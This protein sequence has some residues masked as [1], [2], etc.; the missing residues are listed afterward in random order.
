MAANG[1]EIIQRYNRLKQNRANFDARW[2]EM[3]PYIAP[4]RVG[5]TS[6]PSPGEK[7]TR[8]VYDSSTMMAAEMMAMFIAGHIINPAQQWFE[9]KLRD[10]VVGKM[11]SVKEWLEECRD[12]SLMRLSTSM[13]Y[14]EGPE[15]LIDYGGFGTGFLLTEEIPQPSNMVITGFRGFYFHAEKIGRFVIEEGANGLVDTAMREF[16]LTARVASERW[17]EEKMPESIKNCL[18]GEEKLKEKPFKFIHAIIPRT[19]SEQTAGAAGMP[20][21]SVWV[22]KESKTV[23][24]E[25]GYRVFPA[26]VP[27]HHRTPGEVYGRGRGDLAFPDSWTLNT[28]KRMG[29]EDWAL[30]IRPPVLVRS[31]SVIGS[32]RLVPAGPTTINTHGQKI[33][34]VIAPFETGSRPEVSSL[35][36]EELRRTIREIFYVDTIRQLLETSKSEMTA[37]EFAKKL[38]LLF[39]LMG[40][41]YGRLEWEHLYR[42]VDVIFDLQ[43]YAGGFSD[44]PQEVY[45]TDG[46]IDVEFQNPIAK[47]QRAGGAESLMMAANDLA[48]LG[49]MFPQIW[50]RLDPDKTALGIL[51][52]R[53]VPAQWT[54]NDDEM[55]ALRKEREKQDTSKL[56]MEEVGSMAEAAGKVAPIVKAITQDKK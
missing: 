44:P 8:N 38:E 18:K 47:A 14:A 42:T 24:H 7:Q 4:S 16:E 31:D 30:K 29:L 43:L 9:F 25:G 32:L 28:A 27:R 23:V 17:T 53:G 22:E 19:I 55:L 34:D 5:I 11:D 1:A 37:F 6:Q 3:A 49:Q 20:W 10:P 40:P 21:A 52:I 12:R 2:E 46:K 54:R 36:E 50:D 41:V 45:M 26:S 51:N 35:K 13:F 15:S 48:P 56:Q 39:R 33:T